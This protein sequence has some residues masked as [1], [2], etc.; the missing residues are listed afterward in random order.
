MEY[1]DY[2]PSTFPQTSVPPFGQ[3]FE[4]LY[5]GYLGQTFGPPSAKRHICH[6]LLNYVEEDEDLVIHQEL[7]RPH[8][9]YPG[10]PNT[11][12]V[13]HDLY[14]YLRCNSVA[15]DGTY[16][17]IL[18]YY[19]ADHRMRV[20]PQSLFAPYAGRPRSQ[21][22]LQNS[23]LIPPIFFIQAD[24]SVGL[25]LGVAKSVADNR[26]PQLQYD[27]WAPMEGRASTKLRIAVRISADCP[28]FCLTGFVFRSGKVTIHGKRKSSYEI[29]EGNPY[30]FHGWHNLSPAEW[31][32][33]CG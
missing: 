12:S 17:I 4:L 30:L 7:L 20:V 5:C 29:V 10:L 33:F 13:P 32:A 24:R 14:S 25:P 31:T 16:R 22:E 27:N 6:N 21:T 15:A 28:G 23:N 11:F 3:L 1:G 8:V 2:L 9:S 26:R 19:I 18:D